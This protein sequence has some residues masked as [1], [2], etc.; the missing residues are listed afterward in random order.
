MSA[1]PL[2]YIIVPCLRLYGS[3]SLNNSVEII[4][5]HNWILSPDPEPFVKTQGTKSSKTDPTANW[6]IQEMFETTL[7]KDG[8]PV[9]D[10]VSFIDGAKMSKGERGFKDEGDMVSAAN[11]DFD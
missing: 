3:S 10:P 8:N 5:A 11:D 2:S 6:S 1:T 4:F 7:D 9:P